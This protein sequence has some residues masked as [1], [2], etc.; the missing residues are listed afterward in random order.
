[1]S[2]EEKV[3]SLE[4]ELIVSNTKLQNFSNGTQKLDKLLSLGK[5]SSD[6]SELGYIEEGSHVPSTSQAFLANTGKTMLS[7]AS[8]ENRTAHLSEKGKKHIHVLN[9]V[10][11][12]KSQI[13]RKLSLVCHHCGNIGIF[14]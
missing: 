12:S 5:L 13:A 8:S 14:D 6:K 11:P 1:M 2:L 7:P 10:S 9:F 4:S 3:K